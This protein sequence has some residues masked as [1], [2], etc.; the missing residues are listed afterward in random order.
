MA[1]M[2]MFAG[3]GGPAS[4]AASASG[5]GM[6]ALSPESMAKILGLF[7]GNDTNDIERMKAMKPVFAPSAASPGHVTG[8]QVKAPEAAKVMP[9]QVVPS[10]AQILGMRG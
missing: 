4:A 10:L 5:A 9:Q 7:A 3:A 8:S 2:S 1:L 6:S